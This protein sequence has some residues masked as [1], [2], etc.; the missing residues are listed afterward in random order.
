MQVKKL[1]SSNI[2]QS[3]KEWKFQQ[4]RG[5]RILSSPDKIVQ[6]R[7]VSPLAKYIKKYVGR[8]Q[9]MV[10][11]SL[12]VPTDPKAIEMPACLSPEGV[13]PV[14]GT[15]PVTLHFTAGRSIA[16]A[17]SNS[18]PSELPSQKQHLLSCSS[19]SQLKL[20]QSHR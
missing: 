2:C 15:F 18:K 17:D 7:K 13:C 11:K 20:L 19:P 1:S 9:K 16:R 4:I 12:F 3:N 6:T 10:S 8:L 5:Q 14:A